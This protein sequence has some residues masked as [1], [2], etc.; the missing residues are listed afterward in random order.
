MHELNPQ[1][2]YNLNAKSKIW[3]IKKSTLFSKHEIR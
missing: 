2:M 1:L 3:H